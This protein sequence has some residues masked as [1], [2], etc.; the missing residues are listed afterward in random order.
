MT[1]IITTTGFVTVD[2]DEW[3]T[4]AAM[5]LV[6]LMFIGGCAGSTAGGFKVIRLIIMFR[7]VFQDIFRM[8]HPQAVTPLRVG[9]QVLSERVRI[10]V[11]GLFA[12]WIAVFVRAGDVTRGYP[13]RP[14]PILHRHR[15]SGHAQR[16]RTR[17]GPGRCLRELRGGK[18][19]R[20]L[21]AHGLYAAR[22]PGDLYGPGPPLPGVLEKVNGW[23]PMLVVLQLYSLV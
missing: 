9:D 23:A 14:H 18:L 20:T 17:F 2:F 15:R 10:A 1:S 12:A 22:A 7:T 11:L 21:C 3:D 19:L 8:I 4:G 13:T 5:T 6:F 16:G